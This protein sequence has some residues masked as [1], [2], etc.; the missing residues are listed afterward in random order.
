[1]ARSLTFLAGNRRKGRGE[2][3][4]K[5]K[6]PLMGE[7]HLP[8]RRETPCHKRQHRHFFAINGSLGSE[9]PPSLRRPAAHHAPATPPPRTAH[10]PPSAT[11]TPRKPTA[12]SPRRPAAHRTAPAA[13]ARPP[14]RC[15]PQLHKNQAS[16]AQTA[17]PAHRTNALRSEN[18]RSAS[19]V[20]RAPSA[21]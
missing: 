2:R 4:E 10:S 17:S 5:T 13:A 8:Q 18:R 9:R 15:A 16:S 6:K 11:P 20:R 7:N 14:H 12:H 1:M 19:D 21:P 3:L